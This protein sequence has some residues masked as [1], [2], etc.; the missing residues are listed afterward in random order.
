MNIYFFVQI[1]LNN[2]KKIES[3][4]LQPDFSN[5]PLLETN[6]LILRR[7]SLDDAEEI[8]HLRSNAEVAALTGKAPFV[9]VGEA[10][11]YN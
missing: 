11:A 8:Y 2:L 3:Q 9:G 10:I 7:L 1:L 6:R 5:F 4:M